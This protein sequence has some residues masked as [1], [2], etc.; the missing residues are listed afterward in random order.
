MESIVSYPNRGPWGKSSWRGNTTGHLLVDLFRHFKPRRVVD[1]AEGSG[2]TRDVCRDLQTPYEG[3]DLHS[4]FNL[5]TDS[6]ARAC[7]C[8]PDMVFFHPPYG[9]MITYSGNVWGKP[10]EGDLS[11]CK[12]QEDFIDKLQLALIN[13]YDALE[14]DGHYAVLIGDHRKKGEFRSYQSD[15]IQMGIGSLR[16]VVIKTQHNCVSDRRQYAGSFIPIRHEYLL[17]FRKDNGL[18]AIGP[19]ATQRLSKAFYGTWRNLV[20]FTLRKLGGKASLSELYRFVGTPEGHE[21]S[22]V[23]AKIRQVVQ[24]HFVRVE[25]G[26]YALAS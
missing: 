4:G 14:R 5:L 19:L 15:V 6:L 10:T 2:T 22:H 18:F 24:K 23:Q 25:R 1:P 11:R 16:N 12:D 7:T 9:D 21:N 17:I 20:E 8:A 3:F 13:I 26:V